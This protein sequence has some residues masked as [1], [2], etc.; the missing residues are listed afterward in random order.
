MGAY[1][2]LKV[3]CAGDDLEV[4]LGGG[5][6]AS[7]ESGSGGAKSTRNTRVATVAIIV[8]MGGSNMD[9]DGLPLTI[10]SD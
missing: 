5:S 10:S 4:D 7:G 9:D 8:L 1:L 2:F 3:G 6:G